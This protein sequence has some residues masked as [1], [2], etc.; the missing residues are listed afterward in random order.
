MVWRSNAG[1]CAEITAKNRLRYGMSDDL[2]VNTG[3]VTGG[4]A[5]MLFVN[6]W[7]YEVLASYPR[8]RKVNFP[9]AYGGVEVQ[10]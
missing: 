5:K 6:M 2:A 9:W 10:F 3:A 7:I 8:Q 1:P 4:V